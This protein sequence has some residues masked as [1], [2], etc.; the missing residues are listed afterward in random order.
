MRLSADGDAIDKSPAVITGSHLRAHV[1]SASSQESLIVLDSVREVSTIVVH[2]DGNLT[3]D[4]ETPLFRW[5]SEVTSAV[6]WDG[7][8][9][10]AGW[11]YAGADAS[12]IGAA[13]LTRSGLPFDYRV[14]AAG[15]LRS[16]WWGQPSIAVNEDGV[17]AFVISEAA[18]PLSLDRS[19]LYL[20]SE[21]SAMPAPPAAPTNAVSYFGGSTARIEWQSDPAAGFVIEL[22][23]GFDDTWHLYR[24]VPGDARTITTYTSVGSLFRIRAFGPGGL[25]EGA[26][27]SIGSM[28]RRRAAGR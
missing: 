18:G 8:T 14:T 17:T 3:L 22:W 27:T 4:S 19:R 26:I 24:T 2:T 6:V 5:F 28:Q 25:S 1:A 13:H 12:W 20:A 11:R 21:L 15:T 16:A 9:Y 23:S 10:T 7:A